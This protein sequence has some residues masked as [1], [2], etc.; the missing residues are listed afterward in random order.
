MARTFNVNANHSQKV[1]ANANDLQLY[2][3]D[4]GLFHLR[5]QIDGG[6]Q[7]SRIFP[8]WGG[9]RPRSPLRPVNYPV[10]EFDRVQQPAGAIQ[11][12][13]GCHHHLRQNHPFQRPCSA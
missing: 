11:R 9:F 6:K 10:L 3:L 4:S 1:K 7:E 8:D 5:R 12:S 2:V 13:R